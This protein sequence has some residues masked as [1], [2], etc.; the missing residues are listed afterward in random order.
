MAPRFLEDLAIGQR[1][2]TGSIELSEAESV[3]FAARYD[4]QPMHTDAEAARHGPLGGLAASGWQTTALVMRLL[5][6]SQLLGDTPILGMGVDD[7]RWPNPVRPGD[8]ITAE[9]EVVSI[10]P[11]RSKPDHGVVRIQIVARNQNSEVVLRI[12]PNLWVPRRKVEA[13]AH[14]EFLQ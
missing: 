3:E 7:L 2:T 9:I 4:P 1:H 14:A 12:A 6:E 13:R 8:T 5:I 11:S 10:T